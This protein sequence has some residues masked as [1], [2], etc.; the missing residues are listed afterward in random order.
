MHRCVLFQGARAAFGPP[1]T[2][3]SAALISSGKAI[4]SVCSNSSNCSVVPRA[5]Q[6]SRD[7]G[8][9]PSP[10][11][12]HLGAAEVEP[13]RG[14]RHRLDHRT[15]TGLEVGL[16][17]PGEVLLTATGVARTTRAV[18]PGQHSAAER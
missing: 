7:P 4:S 12:G 18:P 10:Q 2:S 13:V 1:L 16:H 6:R 9:V 8:G 5:D 14:R 17:E 3:S 15:R 11:Q